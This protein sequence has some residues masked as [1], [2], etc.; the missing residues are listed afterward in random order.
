MLAETVLPTSC[1]SGCGTLATASHA[2]L[3]SYW[4][5]NIVNAHASHTTVDIQ[6][7]AMLFT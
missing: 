1:H 7:A 3:R 6:H 2:Q 4:H 5:H